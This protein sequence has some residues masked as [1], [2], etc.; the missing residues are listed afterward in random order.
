MYGKRQRSGHW[1]LFWKDTVYLHTTLI[2]KKIKHVFSTLC[3]DSFIVI[4]QTRNCLF[5]LQ[6]SGTKHILNNETIKYGSGA[7]ETTYA[8]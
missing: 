6:M 1:S 8:A 7:E 4:T 3:T 2:G 5:V